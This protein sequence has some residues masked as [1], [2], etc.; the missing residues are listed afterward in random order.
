[1]KDFFEPTFM[2][3]L[4]V[5]VPTMYFVKTPHTQ[6]NLQILLLPYGNLPLKISTVKQNIYV[7]VSDERKIVK[8]YV[9]RRPLYKFLSSEIINFNATHNFVRS[10]FCTC[11]S[12]YVPSAHW[13]LFYYFTDELLDM[14]NRIKFLL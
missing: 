8:L 6:S 11:R 12:Y 3:T 1:M 10:A 13:F 2:I 9:V 5:R 4:L 14:V 7:N